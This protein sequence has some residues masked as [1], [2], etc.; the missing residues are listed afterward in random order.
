MDRW[1]EDTTTAIQHAP[2]YSRGAVSQFVKSQGPPSAPPSG[3]APPAGII[4]QPSRRQQLVQETAQRLAAPQQAATGGSQIPSWAQEPPAGFYLDVTKDGQKV[5]EIPLTKAATLLGRSPAAD[6]VLDHASISRNHAAL[7][8][9]PASRCMT[10]LDLGSVHGTWADGQPVRRGT[11]AQLQPGSEIRLG[12]STRHYFLRRHPATAQPALPSQPAGWPPPPTAAVAGGASGHGVT[13][14][15]GMAVAATEAAAAELPHRAGDKHPA[16]APAAAGQPAREAKRARV[17]FADEEEDGGAMEQVIGYTQ[18]GSSFSLVGPRPARDSAEGR[19]GDLI[20]SATVPPPASPAAAAA[21]QQQEH[22]NEHGC[23]GGAA[24]AAVGSQ[25]AQAP[26][27]RASAS[28]AAAAAAPW[29]AAGRPGSGGPAGSRAAAMQQAAGA[30]RGVR[31]ALDIFNKQLAQGR[32]QRG[33]EG[34]SSNLFGGLPP[35]SH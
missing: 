2:D 25:H 16:G 34:Q 8:Y 3:A 17:R 6:V 9:H 29:N 19:F 12:A 4:I 32:Q 15:K 11:P 5:Q 23:N 31:S 18:R 10:L 1:S 13:A 20:K 28:D 7:C 21:P 33:G 30:G 26:G 35:P 14:T 22:A 24:A 27:A